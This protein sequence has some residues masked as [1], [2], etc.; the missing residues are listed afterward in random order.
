MGVK[1]SSKMV[2]IWVRV[3]TEDQVRGESPE[4]HEQRARAYCEAK[5]WTVAT[6]YRLEAVSGRAVI[7]HSEARRMLRDLQAGLIS[8]LVFSKLAR[9]ARNTKELLEFAER[10]RAVGAD[11]IS[12]QE[13]ID[14]SSPAGRLFFT[15][16]AAMAQWEREE[17]VERI[18]ASI[19][20][21]AKMGKQVAGDA[22]FGYRWRDRRLEPNPDEAPVRVLIYE[23]FAEHRRKGTVAKI[24]NERGYRTRRGA[25]F[26]DIA[27][28]RLLRDPTAKGIH[29]ANHTTM[30]P[31][32]K[33]VVAKPESEWV[34]RPVEPIV[35]EELWNT[36]AR[37]MAEQETNLKQPTKRAV[38]LFSGLTYCACGAK[39]YVP[40]N[41]AKYVCQECRNKIPTSDLEAI[42]V[43]QVKHRL[44]SPEDI[45]AYSDAAEETLADK[46][47]LLGS[48]QLRLKQLASEEDNLF[49]LFAEKQIAVEDFGRRHRPISEQ[50]TQIEQELPRLQAECDVIR[51]NNLAREE[52]LDEAR[53]IAG[54]WHVLDNPDKR[55]IIEAITSK[56]IVAN[57]NIE[58]TLLQLQEIPEY[59][60][61]GQRDHATASAGLWSRRP[62]RTAG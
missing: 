20:I 6:V 40:S 42:F 37:I 11:L 36:C 56:I 26:S 31:D 28:L 25:L 35:S 9:L 15:M 12:L 32:G 57:D 34:Y 51:I 10:F 5:G 39:M 24:L 61:K 38:H 54:Q 30:A 22:P 19:P 33:T 21:R 53:T 1:D 17:I 47:R 46:E 41:T 43:E 4:H 44:V 16:I 3:S 58:I 48:L 7:E 62:C 8:G 14:T 50:R 55:Q 23:L 27:I 60:T 52:A 45:E 2:G 49:T 13:A 59:A 29:R 18:K